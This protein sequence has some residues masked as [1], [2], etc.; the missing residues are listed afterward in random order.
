[1]VP[2]PLIFV[3]VLAVALAPPLLISGDLR[4]RP[5]RQHPS[6]SPISLSADIL[7]SLGEIHLLLATTTQAGAQ[8]G[9]RRSLRAMLTHSER[10]RH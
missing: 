1:M 8:H 3:A 10:L 4:I 6:I 7:R 5:R 2:F 9:F